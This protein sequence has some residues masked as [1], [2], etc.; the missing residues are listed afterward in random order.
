LSKTQADILPVEGKVKTGSN[1]RD[2]GGLTAFG[3][4]LSVKIGICKKKKI[5]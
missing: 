4:V 1:G 2:A 3:C 5:I